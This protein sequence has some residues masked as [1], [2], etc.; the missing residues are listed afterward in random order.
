MIQITCVSGVERVEFSAQVNGI[1]SSHYIKSF[2]WS[3]SMAYQ[4]LS[5]YG[6]YIELQ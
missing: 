1:R 6:K 5:M 2:T 4:M 3:H